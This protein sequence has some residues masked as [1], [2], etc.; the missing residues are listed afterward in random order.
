MTEEDTEWTTSAEGTVNQVQ[1]SVPE[2]HAVPKP[3]PTAEP[4]ADS[5]IELITSAVTKQMAR[6]KIDMA[7]ERIND[8]QRQAQH[9]ELST[10]MF[11]VS[12]TRSLT[13]L[14][15]A[16]DIIHLP[17]T[18]DTADAVELMANTFERT[19][20]DAERIARA[21]QHIL[22]MKDTLRSDP[23][24]RAKLAGKYIMGY[25]MMEEVEATMNLRMKP[26]IE[27][28]D[29]L[30]ASGAEIDKTRD[31]VNAEITAMTLVRQS[32]AIANTMSTLAD[33]S[34]RKANTA[35]EFINYLRTQLADDDG[36]DT[37]QAI[38]DTVGVSDKLGAYPESVEF[39]R[40]YPEHM[41]D[42]LI[43]LPSHYLY[44][45]RALD[46][47]GGVFETDSLI[48]DYNAD[49]GESTI[50]YVCTEQDGDRV[51]YTRDDLIEVMA[52][53]C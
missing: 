21:E 30:L 47:D 11:V 53:M 18:D 34:E 27:E 36:N 2:L 45:L 39:K 35:T 31:A 22:D 41:E 14:T 9:A 15:W 26:T 46:K 49:T 44:E 5:P 7:T 17:V 33:F 10:G 48:I 25:S 8:A 3:A 37:V 43:T 16:A 4:S 29:A 23:E 24:I 1:R 13:T 52:G 20:N 32:E 28:Y 50:T 19:A 42:T 12:G 40:L 38:T 6:H 51:S